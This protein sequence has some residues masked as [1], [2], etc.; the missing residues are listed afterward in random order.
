MA[1]EYSNKTI[2]TRI[3]ARRLELGMSQEA[4]AEMLGYTQSK[5]SRMENGIG[6]NDLNNLTIIAVGF[7]CP[8][9]MLIFGITKEEVARMKTGKATEK[10]SDSIT[11]EEGN[12]E[13]GIKADNPKGDIYRALHTIE[14]K[15]GMKI[16]VL[17]L[18]NEDGEDVTPWSVLSQIRAADDPECVAETIASIIFANLSDGDNYWDPAGRNLL[19]FLLLYV[20]TG[21]EEASVSDVL[22]TIRENLCDEKADEQFRAT[23]PLELKGKYQAFADDK[24]AEQILSLVECKIKERL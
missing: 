10:T 23:L 2:G 12:D 3:K 7:G 11:R 5:M 17:N 8:L 22:N 18:R 14:Q 9:E 21:R 13:P 20:A 1:Y 24:N 16:Q 6:T 15:T 4:A 19:A